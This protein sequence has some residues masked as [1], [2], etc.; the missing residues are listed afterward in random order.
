MEFAASIPSVRVPRVHDAWEAVDN[1]SKYGPVTTTYIV[2]EFIQGSVLTE[3]WQNLDNNNRHDIYRQVCD[4]LAALHQQSMDRPGPF[5]GG[6]SC[7]NYFSHYGAG[8]FTSSK[9]IESWFNGR[10][11]VCKRLRRIHQDA[12]DFSGLFDKSVMCHLD[13]HT[14]NIILDPRNKVWLLDWDNAGGYPI[15]FEEA[16]LRNKAYDSLHP[17]FTE[18]LIEIISKGEYE[19]EIDR[20][21][22]IRYAVTTGIALEP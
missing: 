9:E 5:G 21:Y 4:M 2:M 12:P 17:D 18:G 19:E 1:S 6:R 8:P 3:I 13:L 7:S 14:K 15:F 16:E 20:L 11:S 10:Q 22:S